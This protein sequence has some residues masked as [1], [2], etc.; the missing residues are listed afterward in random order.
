MCVGCE[1]Y[2]SKMNKR[3]MQIN[4]NVVQNVCDIYT[5]LNLPLHIENG[6]GKTNRLLCFLKFQLST[7]L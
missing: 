4:Q 2:F 5:A 6:G 1:G 7:A 3:G